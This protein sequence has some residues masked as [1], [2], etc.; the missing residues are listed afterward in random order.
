MIEIDLPPFKS[1]AM[2]EM[3]L[4]AY[5]RR[6]QPSA[7]ANGDIETLAVALREAERGGSVIDARESG[8]AYRFLLPYLASRPGRRF[9]LTGA[10]R[11]AERPIIPLLD[12]LHRLGADVRYDGALPLE[13]HGR[14]LAPSAD[15]TVDASLSSQFASAM[16][17]F[18]TTVDNGKRLIIRNYRRSFPY[19]EMT[20][21]LAAPR[22]EYRVADE[23]VVVESRPERDIP[24][25][26]ALAAD[27]SARL[28]V[29]E[30][31]ALSH[32]EAVVGLDSGPDWQPDD[33]ALP[34]FDKTGMVKFSCVDGRRVFSNADRSLDRGRLVADMS[35]MPDAVPALA[36][37]LMASCIPFNMTGV[38]NLR[39]KEC[40]RLEALRVNAR[41]CGWQLEVADDEISYEPMDNRQTGAVRIDTF[42]DHRIAMAFALVGFLRPVTLDRPECVA[43]SWPGF[44]GEMEKLGLRSAAN[45][46]GTLTCRAL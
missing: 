44:Y 42:G 3:M 34:L 19:M 17:L 29:C 30:A 15:L 31:L 18:W 37:A 20:L 39:H 23:S 33:R 26:G 5:A 9:L 2:R 45:P 36:V 27:H 1:L 4:A 16:I 13:I 43:K 41:S 32:R 46:D 10:R 7:A 28:F 21:R 40:D 6:P 24:V 22:L 11:L 12:A 25:V 14:A 35:E 8:T 38:G